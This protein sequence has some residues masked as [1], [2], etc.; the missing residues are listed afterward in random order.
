[1]PNPCHEDIMATDYYLQ[2]EGIKGEPTD[3]VFITA[4]RFSA[5]AVE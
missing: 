4:L 2:L 5:E 1:M 3:S